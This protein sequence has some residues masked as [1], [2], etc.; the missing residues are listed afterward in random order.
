MLARR[1]ASRTTLVTGSSNSSTAGLVPSSRPLEEWPPVSPEHQHLTYLQELRLRDFVLVPSA[2]VPLGPGLVALSGQS[3]AGKS[4]LLEALGQLLGAAA[5]ADCVRP[6]AEVAV[7]EGAWWCA[8]GAAAAASA[9]LRE[10]GL[11]ARALPGGEGSSSSSGGG[12]IHIRREISRLPAAAGVPATRSRVLI[13]GVASSLRVLRALGALLA[14]VNGQHASLALRDAATQ[15]QLLDRIAGTTAAA[16]ALS[17]QQARLATLA[18]QLA[19]AEAL[20][21][22]AERA[23]LQKRL[24]LVNRAG[25]LPGEEVSLRRRL[26][27]L[28]SRRSCL[29]SAAAVQAGIQGDGSGG[30]GAGPPSLSE[31]LR[32][33]AGQLRGVLAAE[34]TQLRLLQQ[35]R[36]KRR[37]QQRRL[38]SPG[39]SQDQEQQY[40]AEAD[41]YDE[42]EGEGVEGDDDVDDAAE[43]EAS[44]AGVSALSAA[45]EELEV[46]QDALLEAQ[47]QRVCLLLPTTAVTSAALEELEVAQEA[48]L[49]AQAQLSS[50]ASSAD[51]SPSEAAELSARLDLLERLCRRFRARG[52]SQ[53][54]QMAEDWS[55]QLEQYYASIGQ[56]EA[57]RA[58]AA[59]L[60]ADISSA[61]L[62]LSQAR[63][64]AAGA[65]SEAVQGCLGQLAMG[66]SRFAVDIAWSPAGTAEQQA[67]PSS[68]AVL[69]PTSA[70]PQP[71][72]TATGSS[73]F[74]DST[75]DK[76]SSSSSSDAPA[77]SS[78]S[79]LFRLSATGLDSVTFLLSAGPAEP[80]RP[81]AA[82]ASGGEAARVMLALKAAPA[83]AAAAAAA[84]SQ[85][86]QSP[87]ADCSSSSDGL[88][89]VGPPVLVMDELDAGLG[90][91]LGEPV[92]RL[93][94]GLVG[95]AGQAR[96]ACQVLMVTHTPQVAAHASRHIQMHHQLQRSMACT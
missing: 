58:E 10:M 91:R 49:E 92:G 74:S 66:S 50:Y 56:A 78:G 8:P 51:Y 43:A 67:G 88:V 29:E 35:Q 13:N 60:Q 34:E 12:V 27:A 59:A 21:D 39:G 11:P 25:I 70:Q 15:L 57:W 7:V 87:P 68:R 46:A 83:A 79:G 65:L 93:L 4:V 52:S 20:G 28:E 96:A 75:T 95:G 18:A 44:A 23:A 61:A 77:G 72:L 69:A 36:S 76:S 5:A 14:D 63:R 54:L 31:A 3:G 1:S 40:V 64:G 24:D 30:G 48:L 37:Q 19:Q 80:L 41:D 16:S 62:A 42:G 84:S 90:S 94:A 22:D 86:Q 2:A 71:L 26:S 6:P 85:Q 17:A 89:S 82:T 55:D 73:S 33:V 38:G 53:L 47:A 81:L 45:L 9:L 32:L